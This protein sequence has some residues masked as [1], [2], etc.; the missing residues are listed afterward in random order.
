MNIQKF[1]EIV[2]TAKAKAAND[3]KWL[4][5]IAKAAD[6]ILSGGIIVTTLAH[7]ALVTTANGTYAAGGH[8]N[9]EAARRGHSQCY[10]KAAARL[11]DIYETET[12]PAAVSF[13]ADVAESS[14]ANLIAEITNIWSRVE[15]TPLAVALMA[16]FG[17]NKL[18]MLDDDLLRRVRL[19]IAM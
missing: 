16:R 15:S 18:E 2:E 12:A 10:H 4:R 19:A 14:R 3:P 8:C 17:K 7:G 1:N 13:G 6:A 11:I 9:C 5:A